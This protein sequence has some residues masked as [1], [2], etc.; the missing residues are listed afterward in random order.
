MAT[1]THISVRGARRRTV[2]AAALAAALAA[3]GVGK[4]T[5]SASATGHAEAAASYHWPVKPFDRQHPVRG[6]FGD[7]RTIFNAAPTLRGV[8]SGGGH[9]DLHKGIDISAPNGSA[10][11]PVVSGVVTLVNRTD[12]WVKVDSGQ[13]RTFEYWHIHAVVGVGSHVEAGKTVLGHIVPPAGHVHLTELNGGEYVNPLAPG[14]LGPYDDGTTPRVTSI[15]FRRSETSRDQLP[16]R[17]RGRVL[18]L[19]T[20]EDDPT[21]SAPGAWR[22]LPVTPAVI[23]WEIRSWTGKVVLP[24]RVA[25]DFRGELPHR[26]LWQVYARGTYQNMTVL[27]RHYSYA[28]P[29]SY[30]FKLTSFDT[31]RLRNGV[32]D[33]VVTATDIRGNSGSLSRR[34]TVENHR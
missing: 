31:N 15:S 19:A 1:Y 25:A 29:G 5:T 17:V 6:G 2:L 18:L 22:G 32:Y 27:G 8:L 30:I 16:N 11:Y 10:V 13:G 24:R 21:I 7:P 34:F 20:A 14:H 3:I 26:N 33:L 28:Q 12:M 4:A 23:S 9:F